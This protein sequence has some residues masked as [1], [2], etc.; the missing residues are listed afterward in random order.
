MLIV[1]LWVNSACVY[2]IIT[3]ILIID[4]L[5]ITLK[6]INVIILKVLISNNKK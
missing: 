2:I 4:D 1:N 3:L 5:T 6:A